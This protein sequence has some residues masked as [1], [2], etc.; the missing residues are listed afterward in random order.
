MAED[1][2]T[3]DDIKLPDSDMGEKIIKLFRVDEKETNI[4]ILTSMGEEVAMDAK[5]APRG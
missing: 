2:S 1:G 4:V 3:K 5:E